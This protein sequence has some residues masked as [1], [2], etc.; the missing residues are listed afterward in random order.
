M[1]INSFIKKTYLRPGDIVIIFL[2]IVCSFLPFFIFTQQP[3]NVAI[4]KV[5]GKTIQTFD[6]I[7]NGP[8]YTYTYEDEDGDYNIIEVSGNKIRMLETNCGD[9]TCVLQGWKSKAGETPI[10]CLPHNLFIIIQASDGS[11]EGSTIY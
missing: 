5:D 11:E 7:E 2:L 1:K 9:Q 6:L 3:G 4:L 8:T 10:A